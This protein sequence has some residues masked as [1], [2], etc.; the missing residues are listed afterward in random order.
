MGFFFRVIPDNIDTTTTIYNSKITSID[1]KNIEVD[2]IRIDALDEN[3]E[4]LNDIIKIVR[5]GA[6]IEGSQYTNGNFN[7]E[8]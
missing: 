2:S 7:R 8:I 1:Y 4:D 6:K 3:I 5:T